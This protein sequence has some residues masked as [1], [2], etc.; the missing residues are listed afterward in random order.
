VRRQDVFQL[1]RSAALVAVLLLS[2]AAAAA[3][4][5]LDDS[6]SNGEDCVLCAG[7]SVLGAGNVGVVATF[8]LV[9]RAV[10]AAPLSLPSVAQLHR[11][12]FLA[13]GPP[14]AS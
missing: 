12:F 11:S 5:D 1:I 9:L 7:H 6:H 4:V 14:A 13:R 3:H 10:P 2:Q 8:D